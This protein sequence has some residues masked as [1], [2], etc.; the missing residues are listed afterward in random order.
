MS[1]RAALLLSVLT[2]QVTACASS[3]DTIHAL[4]DLM[5]G[6]FD[7]AA[8]SNKA[9]ALTRFVDS[10]TRIPVPELGQFVFY[11]Q[12]NQG[13]DL[14]LYRQR[15]LVFSQSDDGSRISSHSYALRSPEN[16]VD[17]GAEAFLGFS[18]SDIVEFMSEGCAQV[19]T[20]TSNGFRG[21][22]DPKTCK[23]VSSRTSK[24]RSIESINLLDNKSLQLVERGFDAKTEQQL[25][26]TPQGQTL[27]LGRI[28]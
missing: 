10:R 5:A 2:Y 24:L 28:P 8:A 20:R 1:K 16:Y 26:G 14:K 15:I 27:T 25:F 23:I 18:A 9:G 19:W 7:T 3:P 22:V 11:Q 4:A 21:Y 6:T 12:L 17:A 13:D